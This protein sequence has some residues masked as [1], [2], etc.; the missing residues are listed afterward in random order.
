M[1]TLFPEYVTPNTTVNFTVILSD[2]SLNNANNCTADVGQASLI[3]FN[4]IDFNRPLLNY[5]VNDV[6][7]VNTTEH[8]TFYFTLNKTENYTFNDNALT[9][10][11]SQPLF[12]N[13]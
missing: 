2:I 13:D 11:P 4:R 3:D 7:V 5:T 12:L 1:K 10:G 9:Y 8:F 6:P